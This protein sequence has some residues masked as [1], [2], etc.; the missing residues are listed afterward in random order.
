MGGGRGLRIEKKGGEEGVGERKRRG[1]RRRRQ[2][3]RYRIE[4]GEKK[5]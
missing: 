2:G 5:Y 3:G 4:R 1:R